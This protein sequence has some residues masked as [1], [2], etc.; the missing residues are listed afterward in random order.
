MN[1]A[2]VLC[3][4]KTTAELDGLLTVFHTERSPDGLDNTQ[5]DLPILCEADRVAITALANDFEIDF[6]SLSFT[7]EVS[8]V[9]HARNFMQKI[10]QPHCKVRLARA[11]CIRLAI[12]GRC[13][14]WCLQCGLPDVFAC[15]WCIPVGVSLS[16]YSLH[17]V[18]HCADEPLSVLVLS[19]PVRS[20]HAL[21][22]AP[23]ARSRSGSLANIH[24]AH[25]TPQKSICFMEQPR[26]VGVA[27]AC[28]PASLTSCRACTALCNTLY[29]LQIIAKCETRQALFNFQNI[30]VA[31]DGVVMSRGNLGLD[32]LPEK[33]A[34][35]QKSV[36]SACNL[37]GK[38]VLLTRVVDTM[39]TA[40]R[41][42]RYACF[43][44]HHEC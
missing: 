19:S 20:T 35:V 26:S 7:R 36:I 40:P 22:Q 27:A 3:T 10:G 1:D 41:P 18:A 23:K 30:A 28:C 9:I 15:A 37:L 21:P 13:E 14:V 34:L 32:V 44:L 42:T 33:M 8:D 11:A 24:S 2:D 43:F 39:I 38:P 12:E 25:V 16:P 4:A 31:A 5:N 29:A 6:L 17:R